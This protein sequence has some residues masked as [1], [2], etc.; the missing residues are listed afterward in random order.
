MLDFSFEDNREN[1]QM[2]DILLYIS[3][4]LFCS[5]VGRTYKVITLK[6]TRQ[7]EWLKREVINALNIIE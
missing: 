5:Y 1:L 6:L 4:G 3:I 7:W 2:L